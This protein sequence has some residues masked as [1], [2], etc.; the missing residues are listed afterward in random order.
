MNLLYAKKFSKDLE[1]VENNAKLKQHLLKLLEQMKQTDSLTGL[2]G[3]R[4]IQG[5]EN[6]YRIRIGD[7]RLGIKATENG[8][9]LLR[10]LHRKDIYRRFP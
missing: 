6:Y 7:Y 5:Y 4:K 9:E 1:G 2:N 8:I 3:V 10:L